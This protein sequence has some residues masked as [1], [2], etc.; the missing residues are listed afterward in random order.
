[1]LPT[2][3]NPVLQTA[4]DDA[5]STSPGLVSDSQEHPS[6]LHKMDVS[7]PYRE[8]RKG[9]EKRDLKQAANYEISMGSILHGKT[10]NYQ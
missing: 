2:C 1:M 6:L 5:L 8:G 3:E 7:G 9:S 4:L 10:H